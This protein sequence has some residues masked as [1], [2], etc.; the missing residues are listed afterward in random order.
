VAEAAVQGVAAVRGA[1]GEVAAGLRDGRR[2]DVGA[3]EAAA[4][5]DDRLVLA[6][7]AERGGVERRGDGGIDRRLDDGHVVAGQEG[8]DAG[9]RCCVR[10]ET[11]GEGAER[12]DVLRGDDADAV[13]G[14]R[15]DGAGARAAFALRGRDDDDGT[16]RARSAGRGDRRRRSRTGRLREDS[17]ERRR[18]GGA[19]DANGPGH[20]AESAPSK[21]LGARCRRVP[22]WKKVGTSGLVLRENR[23]PLA[24]CGGSHG[25]RS[26]DVAAGVPEAAAT[27]APHV[28]RA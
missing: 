19:G 1:V 9:R 17:G 26:A 6:N 3:V 5:Y 22:L 13:A 18:D 16:V 7:G 21:V 14:H 10:A 24:G 27:R 12:R 15:D 23:V 11:N 28:R 4:A 25:P 2:F 8:D 20:R